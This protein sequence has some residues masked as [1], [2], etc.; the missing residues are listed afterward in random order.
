MKE[1]RKKIISLISVGAV[2]LFLVVAYF[3]TTE[4][5]VQESFWSLLPPLIAIV[6]A[7]G[8]KEVYSSLFIGILSGGLLFSGFS[9]EGSI[10]HI[11]MDSIIPVLSTSANVGIICFLV[12]LGMMVQLIN[13][14]GGSRA[15][16]E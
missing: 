3:T 14:T 11:F 12:I 9:F 5:T 13:K 6:L 2:L 4:D 16:G 8:T 10:R 1:E 7:L 15:F